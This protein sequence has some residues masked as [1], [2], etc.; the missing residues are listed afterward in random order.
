[1]WE[2]HLKESAL[3]WDSGERQAKTRV[4]LSPFLIKLA[5]CKFGIRS[6]YSVF[7]DFARIIVSQKTLVQE[8]GFSLTQGKKYKGVQRRNNSHLEGKLQN[9]SVQGK[10]HRISPCP[11]GRLQ[12]KFLKI[13]RIQ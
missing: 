1:M 5:Y 4:V 11:E 6:N 12:P 9:R 10:I 13:L 2:C 7:A 8:C 3:G